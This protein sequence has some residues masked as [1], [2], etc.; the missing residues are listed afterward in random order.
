[1]G[2]ASQKWKT[3]NNQEK[4]NR[5]GLESQNHINRIILVEIDL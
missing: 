4:K 5:Y 1:M 3:I 2:G